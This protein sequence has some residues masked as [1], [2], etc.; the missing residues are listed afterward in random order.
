[1]WSHFNSHIS[2]CCF[3]SRSTSTQFIIQSFY[4]CCQPKFWIIDFCSFTAFAKL[5]ISSFVSNLIFDRILF[6]WEIRA[7]R[8][9]FNEILSWYDVNKYQ[10]RYENLSGR[11]YFLW[12]STNSHNLLLL[13]FF[14]ALPILFRFKPLIQ[15]QNIDSKHTQTNWPTELIERI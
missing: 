11:W 15:T 12:H 2:R 5:K 9:H 10:I 3:S 1:M 13:L 7:R 14:F 8:P 6:Q 4:R